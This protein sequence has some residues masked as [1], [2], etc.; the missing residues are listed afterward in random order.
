MERIKTMSKASRGSSSSGTRQGT[1]NNTSGSQSKDL[2]GH[3]DAH[4]RD[5]NIKGQGHG[6]KRPK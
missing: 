4:K 6:T 1:R 5:A 2:P 3:I